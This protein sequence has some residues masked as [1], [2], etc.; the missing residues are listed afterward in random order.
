MPLCILACLC[1]LQRHLSSADKVSPTDAD[2]EQLLSAMG[3]PWELA[4]LLIWLLQ[5]D[6]AKRPTPDDIRKLLRRLAAFFLPK[7]FEE[8]LKPERL[9]NNQPC[10]T[11]G[12]L[13]A[14]YGSCRPEQLPV[15]LCFG[16]AE[17]TA[18]EQV[19]W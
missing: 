18:G 16:G 5:Q 9:A 3:V 19:A 2:L 10:S 1:W 8:Q 15:S 13:L 17:V 4:Q 12:A 11:H 14:E 6:P 7:T